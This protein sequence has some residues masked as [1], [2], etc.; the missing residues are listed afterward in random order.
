MTKT[1]ETTPEPS[2]GARCSATSTNAIREIARRNRALGPLEGERPGPTSLHEVQ[3]GARGRISRC[4]QNG[5]EP[6]VLWALTVSSKQLVAR[7][8]G[9]GTLDNGD[10]RYYEAA[11][12]LRVGRR[13][14]TARAVPFSASFD[15]G[16]KV[17]KS[18]SFG[19]LSRRR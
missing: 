15:H 7:R 1:T 9:A 19:G 4:I 3:G 5:A 17:S 2:D 18:Q 14:L 6:P 12:G 11:A 8:L 13:A 16:T 10:A